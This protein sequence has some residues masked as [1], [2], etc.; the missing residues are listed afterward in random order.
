M[1]D[2]TIP[3]TA[4][5]LAGGAARRMGRTKHDL[6]LEDGRLMVEL[7]LEACRAVTDHVVVAGPE[8]I[9]PDLPHVADRVEGGGPLSGLDALLASGHGD[10]YL[11]VPCDMPGLLGADLLRLAEGTGDLVVFAHDATEPPRSLP[12]VVHARLGPSITAR[13][14]SEDRSLHGFIA[15]HDA[16][17]VE[18][19]P[20][21]RLVNIN[22]PDDWSNWC[23]SRGGN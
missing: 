5:I 10:R 23:E 19:P 9:L 20:T 13:L 4:A 21:K 6:S 3:I 18:P 16:G 8:T 11:V 2:S 14:E 15:D 12:A 22:D 17:F 1:N 7:V